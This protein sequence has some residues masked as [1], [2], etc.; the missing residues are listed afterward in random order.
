MRAFDPE[1]YRDQGAAQ[2]QHYGWK[3]PDYAK[4][5]IVVLFAGAALLLVSMCVLADKV[6]IVVDDG[7]TYCE[8][9]DSGEELYCYDV[10]DGIVHCEEE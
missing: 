9:E 1:T 5:A 7:V 8:D 10:G 3:E 6:C 2:L 4:R